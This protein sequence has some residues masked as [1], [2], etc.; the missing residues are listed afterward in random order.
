MI[1][2]KQRNPFGA[3]TKVKFESFTFS[4]GEKHVRL[5]DHL[6]DDYRIIARLLNSD[7]IMQLLLVK[8]AIDGHLCGKT[9]NAEIMIPYVPYGRQDR[10]C[11]SGEPLSIKVMANLINSMDFNRVVTFDNHSEVATALINN[12]YNVSKTRIFKAYF[13][14]FKTHNFDAIVV[15]DAGA[16]KSV[17]PV[18]QL[19][20]LPV[21]TA[22]KKRN[23]STGEI[24]N[25]VV[26]ADTDK[27]KGNLLVV[28]DICDGGRTFI[29]LAKVLHEM[30]SASLSLYTTHGI[31][32]KG[33]DPL[34]HYYKYLYTTD[35]F[36][37]QF[38]TNS[39]FTL[40]VNEIIRF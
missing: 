36:P 4:G 34:L 1:E 37:T 12:C 30:G 40:N 13:N 2:I 10:R 38:Y 18:A 32:S 39:C 3:D 27:V 17:F 19:L 33:I 11:C 8:D 21:I 24:T 25:T 22:E 28:D 9:V 29:E 6:Y 31:Y 16:L 7:D 35:S 15:P 23:V 20:E 26:H 5:T 14:L